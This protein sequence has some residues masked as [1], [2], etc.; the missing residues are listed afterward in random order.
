MMLGSAQCGS[1]VWLLDL[2]ASTRGNIENSPAIPRARS[3]R[4][5]AASDDSFLLDPAADHDR[6]L[7]RDVCRITHHNEE[8]YVGA[9][10]VIV[11][12]RQMVHD[13]PGDLGANLLEVVARSLPDSQVRD[14][15]MAYACFPHGTLPPAVADSW[16]S[17]GFVAE[18]VPLAILSAQSNVSQLFETVILQVVAAGGDTDTVA[19]ITGQIAG[20]RVG[21]DGLPTE[22]LTRIDKV[23]EIRALAD[24]FASAV[25]RIQ[26][27]PS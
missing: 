7:I 18:S 10:A 22:L 23:G 3:D 26:E 17:S 4:A 16:G 19:S 5:A 13:N 21:V 6:M 12:I 15:L 1:D 27:A 9:L 11:A 8:A 20:A 25:E 2:C 14:R 24:E